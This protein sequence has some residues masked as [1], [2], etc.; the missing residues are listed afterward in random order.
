MVKVGN[1]AVDRRGAMGIVSRVDSEGVYHGQ[2]LG[3]N[4]RWQTCDPRI[5]DDQQLRLL[6]GCH[7]ERVV[8]GE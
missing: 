1:V 5:V 6:I 8:D 3:T 4:A 7:T 2:R